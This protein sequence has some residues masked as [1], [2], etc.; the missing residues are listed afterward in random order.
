MYAFIEHPFDENSLFC[1]MLEDLKNLNPKTE[2]LKGLI[3]KYR[4]KVEN[5]LGFFNALMEQLIKDD[6]IMTLPNV[7]TL[8]KHSFITTSIQDFI[9]KRKF[10]IFPFLKPK[11]I[12]TYREESPEAKADKEALVSSVQEYIKKNADF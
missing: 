1:Q 12:A 6:K 8:W 2:T 3:E 10:E 5:D 4:A 9:E 11:Q 7:L